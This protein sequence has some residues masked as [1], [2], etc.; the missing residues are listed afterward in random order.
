VSIEG[1]VPV[2]SPVLSFFVFLL[3]LFVLFL[4]ALAFLFLHLWK[5]KGARFGFGDWKGKPLAP[6]SQPSYAYEMVYS[7][8]RQEMVQFFSTD[9]ALRVAE[10]LG[11]IADQDLKSLSNGV[12]KTTIPLRSLHGADPQA[13][14]AA[15]KAWQRDF[16]TI[17]KKL[18]ASPVSAAIADFTEQEV[19]VTRLGGLS[20]GDGF[21]ED[22]I[23]KLGLRSYIDEWGIPYYKYAGLWPYVDT[24]VRDIFMTSARLRPIKFE[25]IA[26]RAFA[27]S[28]NF[29]DW[30]HLGF[31]WATFLG[32][33]LIA[34]SP[35]LSDQPEIAPF[36]VAAIIVGA[37]FLAYSPS[38]KRENEKKMAADP[39]ASD[40]PES[41]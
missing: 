32:T 37:A 29:Y 1:A 19:K 3:S 30:G 40:M 38:R 7:E 24:C 21:G 26:R 28:D 41:T 22:I 35:T 13:Y 16:F 4:F 17:C 18:D 27:T 31:S 14:G 12:A 36:T 20:F 9:K 8:T 34:I 5:K 39:P 11:G 10:L 2:L 6:V 25:S 33:L 15:L 23:G